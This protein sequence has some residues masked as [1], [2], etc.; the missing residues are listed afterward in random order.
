MIDEELEPPTFARRIPHG[1]TIGAATA[2][3]QIEGAVREGGRGESAW[4]TFM[5]EP[6][7][8]LDGSTAA[9][10]DDHFH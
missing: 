2:A 6:G 5:A 9:I 7:R 10:A 8:I 1:F 4:D 3:F